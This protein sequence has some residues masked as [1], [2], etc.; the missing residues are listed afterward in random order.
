ML[1]PSSTFRALHCISLFVGR[2]TLSNGMNDKLSNSFFGGFLWCA[3]SLSGF[4][5]DTKFLAFMSSLGHLTFI[6]TMNL[7]HVHTND[8]D[9][10]FLPLAHSIDC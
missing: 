10:L 3:Y 8:A 9:P 4:Y 6:Y 5:L 2:E 7:T 1:L